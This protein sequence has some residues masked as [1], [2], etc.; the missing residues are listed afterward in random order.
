MPSYKV[1]WVRPTVYLDNA[2]FAV[3]GY[4][5]RIT[6][7]PWNEGRD[8]KMKDANAEAIHELALTEIEKRAAFGAT[9]EVDVNLPE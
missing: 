1:E 9:V 6:I 2:G 7:Y 5:V 3:E 8:L 4:Q